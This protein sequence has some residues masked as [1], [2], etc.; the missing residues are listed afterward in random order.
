MID[1]H[2]HY[3][4]EKVFQAIWRYF[5]SAPGNLW[6]IKY[7]VAGQNL[8]ETINN[9]GVNRFTT[10]VYA[11]K[12]GLASFL[13]EFI[14]EESEKY[15]ALIPFGTIY[16][17]DG[18]CKETAELIFNRY[19]FYGIKL[20]PFVSQE[21]LDDP[22]FFPAYEIME[23]LQ[24]VLVCHPGSAPVYP[25][26]DGAARVQNILKHFPALK[27][28]IA[29]CGASEYGDYTS[30]ADEYQNIYF[31]TAMNCTAHKGFHNDCPGRDFFIKY[32]DRILFGSDFPNIPHSYSRQ[33]DALKKFALGAKIEQKIF[34][35]NAVQLLT[36]Q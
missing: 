4:P 29:H 6:T 14:R 19:N 12:P 17:G 26:K 18:N 21:E 36:L 3:F 20:H 10:L 11:H 7:K 22:R 23:G 34:H 1:T 16:A 8:I 5:E 28:V 32:Q 30:I 15:P 24:K 13:N 33:V 25:K 31:D 2:V 9:E 27:I 35:D